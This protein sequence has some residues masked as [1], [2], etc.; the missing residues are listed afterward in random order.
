MKSR[1]VGP[2]RLDEKALADNLGRNRTIF[3]G[4]STDM[5]AEAVPDEWI[6]RVLERCNSHHNT[7]IFQSKNP[8]RFWR[9]GVCAMV[10]KFPPHTILGTTL[11]T[12][13]SYYDG[14]E[15]YGP[16]PWER[17]AALANQALRKFRKMVSIEPVMAF[18]LPVFLRWLQAI[19]PQFVSI[20]ADS[21]GH[22]LPE[23]TMG[24]LD[25]LVVALRKFT[26]VKLKKN[27]GR[28]LLREIKED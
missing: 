26:E 1:D 12:N 28:L 27:L 24:E 11:E 18:D 4:S 10:R 15:Y 20:G 21:K 23:P 22:N 9:L 7:Y 2:L 17:A 5:W 8:A 14:T 25:M 3:V 6:L 16:Q 19:G 13:R